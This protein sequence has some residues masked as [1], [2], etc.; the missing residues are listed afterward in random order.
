MTC[1]VIMSCER[2]TGCTSAAKCMDA[3][4]P[5]RLLRSHPRISFGAS[6]STSSFHSGRTSEPLRVLPQSPYGVRQALPP[7]TLRSHQVLP[8][9]ALLGN[10]HSGRMC[11]N[12]STSRIE[13]EFVNNITSRSMPMPSPAVGGMPCSSARI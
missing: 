3:R 5:L 4:E 12:N 7:L 1:D 10:A 2:C 8:E 9:L 13:A 6:L 11:G